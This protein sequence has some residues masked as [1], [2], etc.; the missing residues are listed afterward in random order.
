MKQSFEI[1]GVSAAPGTREARVLDLSFAGVA[2]KLP[3]FVLNGAHEGK[4]LVVTAA[5]HGAEYVGT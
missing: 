1:A 5:F 4:T 2:T 3:L